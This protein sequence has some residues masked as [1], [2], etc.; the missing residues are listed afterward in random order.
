MPVLLSEVWRLPP[1][2]AEFFNGRGVLRKY[3]TLPARDGFDRTRLLYAVDL[4]LVSDFNRRI[5]VA[6]GYAHTEE[7]VQ[8]LADALE[9][10]IALRCETGYD[11]ATSSQQSL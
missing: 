6:T 11:E 7:E 3:R 8:A 10:V 1:R 9:D 5:I 2:A 4:F